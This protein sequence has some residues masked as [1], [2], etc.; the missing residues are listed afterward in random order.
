M[1][2]GRKKQTT[3]KNL[4]ERQTKEKGKTYLNSKKRKNEQLYEIQRRNDGRPG[5]H[6][7]GQEG[8]DIQIM[9][10]PNMLNK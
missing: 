3:N 9:Q 8:A 6:A 7:H 2:T 10:N 1:L 5:V 4:K